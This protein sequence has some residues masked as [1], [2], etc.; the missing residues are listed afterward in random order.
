MAKRNPGKAELARSQLPAAANQGS[1][2]VQKA[3]SA[4]HQQPPDD[5]T[6]RR[7]ADEALGQIEWLLRK[8][9]EGGS[10]VEKPPQ[11]S[12]GDL[13]ELNTN[14]LILDSVGADILSDIASD[15]LSLLVRLP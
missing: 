10:L 5:I 7:Q 1:S 4:V 14:R 9:T 8:G 12:Y 11:Q 6:E 2:S 13:S 3:S 15:F